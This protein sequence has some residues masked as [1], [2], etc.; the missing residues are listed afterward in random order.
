MRYSA[1]LRYWKKWEY[2]GT[3]HE[4]FIDFEKA[5][6]LDKK[7][8]S[9]KI[10]TVYGIPI[11]LVRLIRMCLNDTYSEAS[12]KQNK[13]PLLEA[14]REVCIDVNTGKT[15][16]MVVSHHHNVGQKH[17]LLIAHKSSKDVEKFIYLGTTVTCQNCIH[18]LRA[19]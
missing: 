3:V 16:Y 1:F 10:V 2:N 19:D 7:E 12:T 4:L 9:N 13:E 11:K 15:K 5:N 18:K 14:S 8:V 17:N 6:D